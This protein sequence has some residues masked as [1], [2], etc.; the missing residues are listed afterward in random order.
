[1]TQDCG[2]L[3]IIGIIAGVAKDFALLDVGNIWTSN[4]MGYKTNFCMKQLELIMWE[5]KVNLK[6]YF[7]VCWRFLGP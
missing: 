4:D 1:M 3:S 2:L 7:M 5:P 6:R